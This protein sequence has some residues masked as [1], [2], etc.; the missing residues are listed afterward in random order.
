[1]KKKKVFLFYKFEWA[2]AF[3]IIVIIFSVF[4]AVFSAIYDV[5]LNEKHILAFVQTVPLLE[6]VAAIISCVILF[7]F[8][9]RIDRLFAALKAVANGD[10]VIAVDTKANDDYE[11]AYKNLNSVVKELKS[12]KHEMEYFT[13]E[14]LH[15]FK[16]P[17]TAIHGF[18]EHLINTGEEIET[19]ERMSC[20]KIIA[21][22]SI[23]L[24]DLAQKNLILSKVNACQI[25]TNKKDYNL[26]EQIKH[27]TILLLPQIE[28]KN[29]E[30]ELDV[31]N[32]TYYGD[33]ELMEQ[34]WL[35]LIT[36][37]IKFT[38]ENGE[39]SIKGISDKSGITLTFADSGLGMDEETQKHIFEKYFQSDYGRSKGGNGIGL[40]IVNRIVNICGGSIKVDSTENVGSKFTVFL[41]KN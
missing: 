7:L 30:L 14:I 9:S 10:L 24:S 19:P 16:T 18:A 27:C 40:S 21:N 8:R 12:S 20:L 28:K 37:S 23:R 2:I 5:D 22:E 1:M 38:P 25:V 15:E 29:I 17:I 26:S 6:A 34:L 31:E 32:L 41:P 3:N 33:A 4:S 13:N 36:N 35:N 39:I 11:L